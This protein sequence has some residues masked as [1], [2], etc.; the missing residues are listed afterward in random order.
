M[1][2]YEDPNQFIESHLQHSARKYVTGMEKANLIPSRTLA[3]A[4]AERSVEE[5]RKDYNK[6]LYETHDN[7]VNFILAEHE[8]SMKQIDRDGARMA[9]M[10]APPVILMFGA[11]SVYSFLQG[12]P[13]GLGMGA[14][15]AIGSL[16][17]LAMLIVTLRKARS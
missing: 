1:K 11:T 12:G 2:K 16:I 4:L 14:L 9:L 17:F 8:R 7:N 15:L 13:V 5:A 6:H 3:K 10:T